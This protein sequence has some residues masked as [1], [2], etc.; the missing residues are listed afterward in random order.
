[1]NLAL[2]DRHL[3]IGGESHVRNENG[4]PTLYIPLVHS[5]NKNDMCSIACQ[6][7]VKD[8]GDSTLESLEEEKGKKLERSRSLRESKKGKDKKEKEGTLNRSASMKYS[9]DKAKALVKDINL[10]TSDI[11]QDKDKG[12]ESLLFIV[13]VP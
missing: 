6:T 1:M 12:T 3:V 2:N 4:V 7:T 8:I 11:N 9:E 10:K 13:F 5:S